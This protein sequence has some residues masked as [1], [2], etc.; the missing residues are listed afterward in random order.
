MIV[1]SD[2]KHKTLRAL[3]QKRKIKYG[4]KKKKY[5]TLEGV[6]MRDPEVLISVMVKPF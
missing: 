6:Q 2:L 3:F 4:K 1:F 5:R